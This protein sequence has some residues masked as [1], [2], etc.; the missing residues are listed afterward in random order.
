MMVFSLSAVSADDLQTTDSG[1]VSGDVDVATVNPWATS[2]ELTYDIP[3]D[4]DIKSADVYV[5]VYGGSAK[6]TH[7]ANAN[8]SLKTV[9]GENQIASE[10]LWI[11]DGTT[12]GT[13]YT[14]NNH[15]DKCYSDYQM[16]YDITDSIKGL[17]GSSIVLKVDTFKMDNKTFDGRIKLI[18]LVL[19]Y[20]DGDSD[21][22]NYW[23]DSTQKWTK[24]NIT[25]TFATK[26]LTKIFAA[27]LINVALSSADGSFK[28]N[29][30][31]IGDAKNHSAGNY[32]QYNY[33]DVTDKIKAGYDTEFVSMN[34]GTSS[35][36]S[37]KNVLSVLK[38]NSQ[39]M[40]DVSLA[41]EYS[42]TCY[43]GTNN[44]ITVTATSSKAGKYLIELLADGKVVNSSEIDL[45]GE[46]TATLLL[47]DP[48]IRPIDETTVNGANNTN[49]VYAVNLK[50]NG[51]DVVSANKTVPVLYNGNLGKDLAYN[52]GGFD[53]VID[54]EFTGGIVVD[55]KSESSYK[56]GATGTTEIWAVNLANNSSIVKGFIYVPYNWFNG[57]TYIENE[58]M[59]NVSFNNVTLTPLAFYRDQSNLGSYG[60]YGYGVLVYDVSELIVNGNNTFELSKINPTPTIYPSTLIYAYDAADSEFIYHAYIINGA[61]LLSNSN[62][63]AG[64]VAAANSKINVVSKDVSDA[65]LYI[66]AS[67]AQK[68]EGN[69][70]VNG[71]M[72]EDVWNGT[73][74]TTDLYIANIT[75]VLKD[76]NDISFVATGSTILALHQMIVTTQKAPVK[77]TVTAKALSTTYD[78]GKAFTMTVLDGDKK[79]VSGL[80]LTLK[81]Y[82]G[83]TSKNYYATT[84]SNGVAS[85]KLASIL[86]IGTHK[87]EITSSNTAYDVKKTTSSIKVAK[88]KTTVK[89]PK[90][91]AKVKKTKYFKVTVKNKASKKVV[92]GLKIKVK[93]YTGK[94][95]KTYTIKTNKKGVAQLNT[96]SLKVGN[97]KVVISSGNAKYTVSAK[98]TI[99]IKK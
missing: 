22:I 42:N 62:N 34:V 52:A 41:T 96:K 21:V 1:Q 20:D 55:T 92:K 29:G 98:S 65:T 83:K 75:D 38:V 56:S 49:V 44:T 43:A 28:I 54:I 67:G 86:A 60:K 19:A 40:A 58:T 4:A 11:E 66:F 14:V 45:D 50:L 36:S 81:V 15:T 59:F 84:N 3:A 47:T 7:G 51:I 31:L 6:N 10:E 33:W 16:H 39:I 8:V 68:G 91:T 73:S 82:T 80:K 87:V 61:D 57:K 30:E 25:T 2:G 93:V 24:T 23:V 72:A 9:N 64:R 48:T 77:T 26:D 89:A 46:N 79:P 5:N 90:V 88:A 63:N 94:K 78:S 17:N 95:Y 71:K 97:H 32:Y 53:E 12:D 13:I 35:Y 76:S 85:F 99:T 74:K 18:A 27:D 69:I 37:L 70:I